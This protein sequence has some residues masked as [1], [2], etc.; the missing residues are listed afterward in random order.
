MLFMRRATYAVTPR[1][2]KAPPDNLDRN[3]Q[4][5]LTSRTSVRKL[6][7]SRKMNLEKCKQITLKDGRKAMVPVNQEGWVTEK[8]G[9]W[10][11]HYSLYV[12][13]PA[14][15]GGWKRTH[16]S[17][18]IASKSDTTKRKARALIR[19]Y[20]RKLLAKGPKPYGSALTF[21][22]YVEGVFIP[23]RKVGWKKPTERVNLY[24]IN[25]YL[26]EHFGDQRMDAIDAVEIATFVAELAKK[27]AGGLVQ[28]VY[29]HLRA[30]MRTAYEL[31]YIPDN[32]AKAVK[33]PKIWRHPRQIMTAAQLRDLLNNLEDPEDKCIFA[34]GAF[35]A[36][37]TSEIFGLIWS[38]WEGGQIRP[39]STAFLGELF[40]D[41]TKTKESRGAI[42]LGD[43]ARPWVE[44]WHAQCPDTSPDALIFSYLPSKGQFKGQ[45]TP[46]DPYQWWRKRVWPVAKRLG[47]PV[48][49][50][51]FQVTRRTA[52]TLAMKYGSVKDVQ[53][54]LRHAEVR[55]TLQFYVQPVDE[56][57]RR[58]V[59][60][61]TSSVMATST[62]RPAERPF[63][64]AKNPSVESAAEE[65]EKPVAS[66]EKP[67]SEPL[68]LG[69]V[70]KLAQ[71]VGNASPETT[72]KY[73]VRSIEEPNLNVLDDDLA[74]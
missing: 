36:L 52:A 38:A 1:R 60:D 49:L 10:L 19:E 8:S 58:T 14:I 27:Y 59:N 73:Y 45:V 33:Q 29:S 39:S 35:C 56:S 34:V 13:D 42:P 25:H 26:V 3:V 72:L 43:V 11:G 69:L 6:G 62:Q 2:W 28:K 70:K 7:E 55:T 68:Q 16:E 24:C 47:I 9:K 71:C 12:N 65:I 31:N 50:L 44:A 67:G 57:T 66:P 15:E 53:Q 46:R 51:T 61:W 41:N 74:S 22:E 30:I 17:L 5:Q 20:L 63:L 54:F 18:V 4:F 23:L 48:G 21:R 37:R 40:R 64:V 32:P